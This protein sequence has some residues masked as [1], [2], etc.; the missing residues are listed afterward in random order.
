MTD[1]E[2]SNQN[3]SGQ[4][5]II[6]QEEKKSNGIGTAGFVLALIALFIGWV[7]F[8]GWII[9][10]L[11]LIFSFVGVFKSPKGLAIAGL[12]I[13]FI[14]IILLIFIFGVIGAAAMSA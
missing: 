10:I 8:I 12:V 2:S 5:I 7:P 14:G 3:N 13:S 11:G 9:W 6:K 1:T 4:T